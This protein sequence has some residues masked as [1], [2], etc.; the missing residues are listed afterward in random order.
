MGNQFCFWLKF[1][2]VAKTSNCSDDKN[3][4]N[5]KRLCGSTD[6]SLNPRWQGEQM[7]QP[8]VPVP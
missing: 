2:E 5:D 8:P 4:S 3:R 7:A 1:S 6:A